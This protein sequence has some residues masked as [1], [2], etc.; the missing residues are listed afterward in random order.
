MHDMIARGKA[1]YWGTSEWSA[2]EI[3]A[4]GK[5]ATS[6]T[7]HKPVVEQPQYH[8]ST[9]ARPEQEYCGSTTTS[10]SG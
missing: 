5:I 7:L 3:R 2:A 8:C 1:L 10:A 9:A 6:T 4:P